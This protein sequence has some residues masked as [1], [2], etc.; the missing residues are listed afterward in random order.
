MRHDE[1]RIRVVLVS[2]AD[3]AEERAA[4]KRV[5]DELNRGNARNDLTLWRWE[6][7]ARAGL[8]LDG[9]QGLIDELMS[10]QDADLVIGVFWTRFGTPTADAG[11]GTE[12]ELRNAWQAWR[13]RG[14]P[15]VMVYFSSRGSRLQDVREAAQMERLLAFRDAMPREQLWW[16]YEQPVDFERLL[17]EHLTRFLERR[18]P[19]TVSRERR[20]RFNLPD[21]AASFIGRE[22]E[23]AELD[24][25]LRAD[26]HAVVTQAITGL[27]GVG[28]SQL[29]ARYAHARADEY[30][31]V[32]WIHAEDGGIA[33]L[34]A[35]GVELGIGV[36]ER[37]P[38]EIVQ[39]TVQ[40]LTET[41]RS[42]LLILDNVSSA[43][44]LERV[45][46]Q[47]R[48]GRVLV[49][50]RDRTLRRYGRLVAVDVFDPETAATYLTE[51]ADR[52]A[53]AAS[54]R[55]LAVALGC[56]PLALSHAAAYCQFGVSFRDYLA[57]LTELP[58]RDLFD[59]DPVRSHEQ[60]VA[61]TWTVSI[62]AASEGAPLAKL[63]LEMAAFLAPNA[64]PKDLF[65]VLLDE[66]CAPERK[67]LADALN[68][69]ARYSLAAV[70]EDGVT[71]H[72]LLAR[73]VREDI[74]A[75]SGAR[76]AHDALTSVDRAFASYQG[77]ELPESWPRCEELL[78]HALALASEPADCGEDAER[79]IGLLIR[80]CRYLYCAGDR[81]RGLTAAATTAD[82]S[83][84]LLGADHPTTLTARH[85]LAIAHYAAR[86]FVDAVAIYEPLLADQR[87]VHGD[88][89]PETLRTR[90]SLAAAYH[91]QGRVDDAIAIYRSLLVDQER[92]LGSDH[93]DTLR[94]RNNLAVACGEADR[95]EAIS[96]Y[97]PLLA[98]QQRILGD[99]HPETLRTRSNLAITKELAGFPRA[100]VD[101]Y[102]P[103]LAD[104]QRILGDEHPE[105]LR[106]RSNLANAY[107]AAGRSSKAIEDY[108]T[109]LDYQER[110]LGF[111]HA[112]TLRTRGNLAYVYQDTRRAVEAIAVYEPLLAD[113]ERVLG[114]D[115]PEVLR[116]RNN[117]AV[118]YQDEG[119]ADEAIAVYE[120]LL[121]AQ[122][123]ILGAKHP[124]TQLAMTNLAIAYRSVGRRKDARQLSRARRRSARERE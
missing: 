119:R 100:A 56:L 24:R 82:R 43:E 88:E 102:Q 93:A 50:S 16:S 98:D 121:A 87:A 124:Q 40:W 109:L 29:A 64:I 123:R 103:L 63:V 122:R 41:D 22:R 26:A 31:I 7:D 70:G 84:V 62:R 44:Q 55:E 117:L 94:T 91:V 80:V 47:G 34:A 45:R 104:Q 68:A 53:D 97:E 42:W 15:E 12:H 69:L 67:R 118:A 99:E 57:M 74:H 36:G 27:G 73:T 17:R 23:L 65:A 32:A 105:T 107:R 10:I 49:T 35:L 39:A 5:I 114:A 106:T 21:V 72:R 20:I 120:H 75:A 95:N 19:A 83:T 108:E 18:I 60:A 58:T 9:P 113:M 46:P 71:V 2:P 52:P 79:L 1:D 111:D 112:D 90:N 101:M 37:A 6:T 8:H 3:V 38:A 48:A 77:V 92:V 11:S 4:A 110:E 61:S 86:R 28:K 116:T 96:I 59:T 54:A 66:D 13:T 30:E 78:A 115:H 89:H 25:S 33:D 85:E 51:R 76:A 81:Q 14:R